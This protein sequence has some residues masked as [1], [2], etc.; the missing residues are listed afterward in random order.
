LLAAARTILARF[1]VELTIP[2]CR[3]PWSCSGGLAAIGFLFSTVIVV[4]YRVDSERACGARLPL[5]NQQS[6]EGEP[7]FHATPLAVRA[8]SDRLTSATLSCD[9]RGARAFRLR[10]AR[11]PSAVRRQARATWPELRLQEAG[12]LP[13]SRVRNDASAGESLARRRRLSGAELRSL[14]QSRAERGDVTVA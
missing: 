7:H 2:G 12:A 10:L 6:V 13:D 14:W 3:Q 1:F 9:R 11:K 8:G 4:P 5:N